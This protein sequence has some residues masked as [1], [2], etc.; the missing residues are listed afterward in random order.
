MFAFLS[1]RS[2]FVIT[3]ALAGLVTTSCGFSGSN[4]ASSPDTLVMGFI[5]NENAATLRAAYA[6]LVKLISSASGKEVKFQV[7]TN[8][9]ALIEGQRAGT[10]HIAMYGPLSYV[11]AKQTGVDIS[12]IG[13]EL[14][15]KGGNPYYYSLIVARK[16]SGLKNLQ[17]L[18]GKKFCFVDPESTSGRL[19]PLAA[20]VRAGLKKGD[21]TEIFAGGHDASVLAVRDRDCDAGASR[22]LIF[23]NVLP[24]QKGIDRDDFTVLW[25]S[26]PV[27]NS[28]LAISNK[29]NAKLR[30]DI[31]TAVLQRGNADSLGVKNIGGVWGYIKVNDSFYD[32]IRQMCKITALEACGKQ[33]GS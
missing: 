22:D 30:A 25:Q 26:G 21:Y 11:L 2:F 19:Y 16:D 15:T 24:K 5:P 17:D 7:M 8:Y 23:K 3:S 31:T 13:A 18:R 1:K 33:A 12:P 32:P 20:L 10:V 14:E 9:A 27:V 4:N 29:L 28:P 6:P